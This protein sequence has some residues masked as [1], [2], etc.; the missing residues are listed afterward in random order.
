MSPSERAA[1]FRERAARARAAAEK[2]TSPEI[3][4]ELLKLAEQWERL[5][6]GPKEWHGEGTE[7]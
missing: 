5:A 2:A 1:E 7:S 4:I 3:R 6:Q